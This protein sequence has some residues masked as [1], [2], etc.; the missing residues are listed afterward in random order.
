MGGVNVAKKATTF[1]EVPAWCGVRMGLGFCI[2]GERIPSR[3]RGRAAGS[4]APP[5]RDPGRRA[6]APALAN[7]PSLPCGSSWGRD[8][9][10]PSDSLVYITA[11]LLLEGKH[12]S[13]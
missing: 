12:A 7:G 11:L 8:R 1:G 2:S 3:L 13:R 5:S 4:T 6:M 10:Y 9:V